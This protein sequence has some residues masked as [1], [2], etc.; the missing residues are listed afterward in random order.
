M[1][2]ILKNN[3]SERRQKVR[4]GKNDDNNDNV[5]LGRSK[6]ERKSSAPRERIG[7]PAAIY[8]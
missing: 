7:K 3:R 2:R 4:S 6:I 8:A 5:K 1:N